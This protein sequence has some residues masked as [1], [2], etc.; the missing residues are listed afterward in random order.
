MLRLRQGLDTGKEGQTLGGVRAAGLGLERGPSRVCSP[1]AGGEE[2]RGAARTKASTS[3]HGTGPLGKK[4]TGWRS[5]LVS[6]TVQMWHPD[7]AHWN[8]LSLPGPTGWKFQAVLA[9]TGPFLP[10]LYL[11]VC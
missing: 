3:L 6:G 8:A 9:G 10:S 7:P 2:R 4:R 1:R 5:A 11:I